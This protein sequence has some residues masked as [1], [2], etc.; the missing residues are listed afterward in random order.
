MGDAN[1]ALL[2]VPVAVAAYGAILIARLVGE[3]LLNW[4]G[5]YF[6]YILNGATVLFP[7]VVAFVLYRG[8]L[9]RLAWIGFIL[10]AFGYA[11]SLVAGSGPLTNAGLWTVFVAA[12]GLLTWEVSARWG[13]V[14]EGIANRRLVAFVLMAVIGD[15]CLILQLPRARAAE[16]VVGILAVICVGTLSAICWRPARRRANACAA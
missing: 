6:H 10:F 9:A 16:G 12:C 11:L 5:V 13:V 14:D 8:G 15:A 7:L 1:K 4:D 3:L 2:A